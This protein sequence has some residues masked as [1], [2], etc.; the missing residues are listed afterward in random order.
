MGIYLH[1]QIVDGVGEVKFLNIPMIELSPIY[2]SAISVMV[3][4]G[5]SVESLDSDLSEVI[6]LIEDDRFDKMRNVFFKYMVVNDVNLLSG[7]EKIL[8]DKGMLIE[9]PLF[10]LAV[11][12]YLGKQL[13]LALK[14]DSAVK[15]AVV[16]IFPQMESILIGFSG[17]QLSEKLQDLTK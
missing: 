1:E 6:G 13:A 4:A 7:Y 12:T 17:T 2:R 5:V 14:S 11:K 15:K 9:I 8:A 3:K 16:S 10:A